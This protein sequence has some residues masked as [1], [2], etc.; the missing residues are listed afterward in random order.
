MKKFY[1]KTINGKFYLCHFV[2]EEGAD[3]AGKC[4]EDENDSYRLIQVV[5][6][7][8]TPNIKEGQEFSDETAEY[9]TIK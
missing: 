2:T 6:E 5:G 1:S 8:L 7:I 3:N 4:I 9:L